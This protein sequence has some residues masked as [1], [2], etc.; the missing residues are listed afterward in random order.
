MIYNYENAKAI[1]DIY[2]HDCTFEGFVYDYDQREVRFAMNHDWMGKR[3]SLR[4]Q[5]VVA[6][7]VQ[8]CGF[9]GG[10]NA[11][12]HLW[13]DDDPAYFHSLEELQTQN[14]ESYRYSQLDQGIRFISLILQTIGGDELKI[15]CQ[16]VEVTEEAKL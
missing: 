14:A 7:Q 3:Y 16:Q 1:E 8:G 15:T 4:F 11:V 2:F 13:I 10:C 12:Y 5:N 9:W 6:L